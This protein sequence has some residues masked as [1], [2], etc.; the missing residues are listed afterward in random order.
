[1]N[2]TLYIIGASLFGAFAIFALVFAVLPEYRGI[3]QRLM[4]VGTPKP[5]EPPWLERVVTKEQRGALQIRL[6][7]AGWHRVKPAQL[8]LG[9][10]VAG[11]AVFGLL[12]LLLVAKHAVNLLSV[13]VAALLAVAAAYAPF[14]RL[15]GDIRAR[16]TAV[17]RAL[18]DLL[19]ML[20]ANVQAGLAVNAAMQAAAPA[21]PGPLGEELRT[22]LSELRM[23]RSREDVLYGMANRVDD[24]EVR[25]FVRAVITAERLGTNLSELLETLAN[26]ARERRIMRAEE[27]AAQVPV[28][29]T[30][31]MALFM[32]PALFVVI[33]G[34][35]AADYFAK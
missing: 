23:G 2:A 8:V 19:D 26:E 13:D 16:E 28:K 12:F 6:T 3:R 18:P 34:A 33:F 32:L 5:E 25:D 14:W 27:Y 21:T 35:V 9:S 20:S 31:P 30:V 1:M 17:T 10:I 4:E 29:M 11:V 15:N 22:A 24:D 7:K